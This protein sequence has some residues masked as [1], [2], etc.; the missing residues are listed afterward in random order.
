MAFYAQRGQNQSVSPAAGEATITIDKSSTAVR[1]HNTGANIC[2]VRIGDSVSGTPATTAD[3]PVPA[4][5]VL[6][7]RKSGEEDTLSH[8]S[9]VG[10]TLEVQTG[11]E[12]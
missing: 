8:I 10:T 1:L 4:G 11:E 9:A 12:Y 2:H 3:T 7:L 6:V 5:T